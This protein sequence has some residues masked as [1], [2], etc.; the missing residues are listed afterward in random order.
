MHMHALHRCWCPATTA[1]TVG[2]GRL[3]FALEHNT[4]YCFDC[5][6]SQAAEAG[7]VQ[8]VCAG[9]ACGWTQ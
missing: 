1:G 3:H 6:A 2:I 7:R 4:E 8:H 9:G 5:P